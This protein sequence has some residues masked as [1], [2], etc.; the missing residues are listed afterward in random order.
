MAKKLNSELGP[1]GDTNVFQ[2]DEGLVNHLDSVDKGLFSVDKLSQYNSVDSD[3][4]TASDK[5]K[6][7]GENPDPNMIKSLMLIETG[8]NPKKNNLGYEGY[9]QTNQSN[10]DYINSKNNTDFKLEDMYDPEKAATYIH[11]YVKT[12]KQS[13]HVDNMQDVVAVYNWGIGNF[14]KY[15]N[16]LKTMPKQTERYVSLMNTL[17]DTF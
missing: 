4:I 5:L 2:V 14:I 10:I 1:V 13:K 15:K 17:Q 9:P 11:Y 6:T 7:L 16:G 12:M 3:I 8:M